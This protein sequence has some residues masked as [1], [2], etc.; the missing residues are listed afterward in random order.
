M[1]YLQHHLK[2]SLKTE[3]LSNNT[4]NSTNFIINN[5]FNNQFPIRLPVITYYGT[6]LNYEFSVMSN[7]IQVPSNSLQPYHNNN[8]NQNTAL[9]L[10]YYY[11][12]NSTT[13]QNSI[14]SPQHYIESNKF[15][16]KAFENLILKSYYSSDLSSSPTNKKKISTKGSYMK[17]LDYS[18]KKKQQNCKDDASISNTNDPDNLFLYN[19]KYPFLCKDFT[20]KPNLNDPKMAQT[21]NKSILKIATSPLEDNIYNNSLSLTPIEKFS[22]VRHYGIDIENLYEYNNCSGEINNYDI[23][24]TTNKYAF[25]NEIDRENFI[26]AICGDKSSGLHYGIYTCEGC[27]G[28]FKR[29]VQ[30][31]RVYSCVSGSGCCPMTKE[32]RNRCQYCR[33][34]KCL[35]KGMVLEA[36]REDRM[37][38]GRN[39]SAIYNLYKLK[40]RKNKRSNGSEMKDDNSDKNNCLLNLNSCGEGDGSRLP[41]KWSRQEV[42]DIC[43][44]SQSSS[45]ISS[46]SP[47]EITKHLPAAPS[48]ESVCDPESIER[49]KA[50]PTPR[51]LIHE[52]MEIDRLDSLINLKGLRVAS[53]NALLNQEEEPIPACQ[54]LSRIGDEIVEQLVEW[55]KMLPF[56]NDLPVEIHTHLLTQ[57]WAELV[58]LSACYYAISNCSPVSENNISTIVIKKDNHNYLSHSPLS[59]SS[60][61]SIFSEDD[62]TPTNFYNNISS[63]SVNGLT[64]GHDEISFSDPS[65]N[66]VILQKRLS[67]I[68]HKDIP[69]E[70]VVTEAGPLVE[71][72]TALLNSFAKL[73]ITY[74]AYV[75]LKAITLLHYTPPSSSVGKIGTTNDNNGKFNQMSNIKKVSII[76]DQFVKALQIHLS[77]CEDGPRLTDILT[78]LPMLHQA[79]SVL[80]HS[81]MFYVPFLICKSPQSIAASSINN[82]NTEIISDTDSEK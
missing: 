44:P 73:K 61:S 78:W 13:S 35:K 29:T 6:S 52:M 19:L 2:N 22:W 31:K 33:F 24:S 69:M 65:I 63:T 67:L 4:F 71:K 82:V 43:S 79:S 75:C 25:K 68:M 14:L 1:N 56:Y 11:L 26:C 5:K 36:V 76:Q 37:P 3:D 30:N 18:N 40:Y 7:G 28:F 15:N 72:F 17:L 21:K 55:T 77:Q 51:N 32:H 49:F 42:P 57:R 50:T 64:E 53:N 46:I 66:L 38:G 45:S 74:E 70:H 16:Q 8:V 39:G 9:A 34:K 60:S 27:K 12:Q 41:R 62:L 58:L 10:Y 47:S 80:L 81:K 54:R 20:Y 59:N 48:I 23:T